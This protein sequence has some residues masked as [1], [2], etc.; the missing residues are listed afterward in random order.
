MQITYAENPSSY[1]PS[2]DDVLVVERIVENIKLTPTSEKNVYVFSGC[3]TKFGIKNKNGRIYEYKEFQPHL[4]MLLE[5]IKSPG[6]LLGEL[7]HPKDFEILY[8]RVSHVIESLEYDESTN[9]LNG[10]IRLLN[11][12][13]G[14][15]AMAIADAGVGLNISSRAAGSVR[16]DNTVELKKVFTYDLVAD[17]GFAQ[18]QLKRVNETYGGSKVYDETTLNLI[19]EKSSTFDSDS[20]V[21]I[22]E[23]F[24]LSD[25]DNIHIFKRIN[26]KNSTPVENTNKN[27][28]ME[29]TSDNKNF[30]SISHL[31]DWSQKFSTQVKGLIA[32]Q[33]KENSKL[34]KEDS[35]LVIEYIE[36]LSEKL[37]QFTE[38][39][40]KLVEKLN[41]FAEWNHSLQEGMND[42]VAHN[43]YLSQGLNELANYA[44]KNFEKCN[45]VVEHNEH[46][47]T[48][49]NELVEYIESHAEKSNKMAEYVEFLGK[50]L[51]ALA[52]Y[53]EKMNKTNENITGYVESSLG[54]VNKLATYLN[55]FSEDYKSFKGN[56]NMKVESSFDNQPTFSLTE[57]KVIDINERL[58]ENINAYKFE[59][60]NKLDG[61]MESVKKQKTEI[62]AKSSLNS[63]SMLSETQKEHFATLPVSK[64]QMLTEKLQDVQ[65]VQEA[66]NVWNSFFSVTEQKVQNWLNNMPIT[67]KEQWLK[68]DE[69]QQSKIA[70]EAKMYKFDGS[71]ESIE[72]FWSTRDLRTKK[73][74][75]KLTENNNNLVVESKNN[76]D[77]LYPDFD[78]DTFVNTMKSLYNN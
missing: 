28:I 7:D 77:D 51:N 68:L 47:T 64:K 40:D 43:D 42:L 4:K 76:S 34:V 60:N 24:G 3:F 13:K 36:S 30:V 63:I 56:F 16:E 59:I 22:N 70:S 15:D 31:S 38:Y 35:S 27:K 14:K 12:E 71:P 55:A 52:N 73:Y 54:K 9:T 58:N 25:S 8:S 53:T 29:S 6:K 50:G 32:D 41:K 72:Y 37:N 48:R 20:V 18:A 69:N 44:E 46:T 17:P 57:S 11:T 61:L 5:Q 26:N 65:S 23:S 74:S 39:N 62:S 78:R 19:L 66:N 45:I 1:V 33:V 2:I 75:N 21:C 10:T 67:Y 49:A